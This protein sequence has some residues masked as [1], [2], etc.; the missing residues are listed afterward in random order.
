[1]FHFS[2]SDHFLINVASS[3]PADQNHKVLIQNIEWPSQSYKQNFKI[4]SETSL[5][6]PSYQIFSQ[7]SFLSSKHSQS[8]PLRLWVLNTFSSL[9]SQKSFTVHLKT[10][11][12]VSH[13]YSSYL[14][15]LVSIPVIKY[16]DQKHHWR[17][18]AYW[19]TL[20]DWFFMSLGGTNHRIWIISYQSR[21]F[22]EVCLLVNH[23]ETFSQLRFPPPRTQDCVKLAKKAE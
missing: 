7:Q 12:Q 23:K 16:H 22:P 15:I 8:I 10:Y 5:D 3:D 21:N 19:I 20:Y 11:A 6:R 18:A 2:C 13:S 14:I 17:M 1:M 9:K 4:L